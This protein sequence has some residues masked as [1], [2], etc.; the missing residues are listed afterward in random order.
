[1]HE[2]IHREIARVEFRNSIFSY[3]EE[4]GSEDIPSGEQV[5]EPLLPSGH[6]HVWAEQAAGS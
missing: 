1:M 6:G 3:E 2:R 4:P 5:P